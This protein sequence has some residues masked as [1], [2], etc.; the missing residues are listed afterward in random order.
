MG[1]AAPDRGLLTIGEVARLTRLT[2]KALRLYDQKGLLVPAHVDEWTGYRRYTA[3]QVDQARLI[4]LLRGVDMPLDEIA[5]LL[6]EMTVDRHAAIDRL[7]RHL[8]E[9]ES[10]QSSR[11]TLAQHIE[12]LMH[13]RGPAMFEIETRHVPARR[14]MSIQRR[15]TGDRTDAFVAEAK[16]AFAAHLDGQPPR[17]PFT[18]IFHGRVDE[19][20]DGPLEAILACAADVAPSEAIGIRTEPAHNEAFT[21]ITKAQWAF[22]AILAAYDAV[23]ASPEALARPGELSCR[24]VYLAEPDEIGEHDLICDVAFPL[25]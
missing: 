13:E 3:A 21:T 4:A 6:L 15:L 18:V 11:R 9:L 2:P 16:A 24:E 10:R 12:N 22:P 8:A 25:G 17:G 1:H 23:A 20:H 5:A 7:R 19:E 14:V